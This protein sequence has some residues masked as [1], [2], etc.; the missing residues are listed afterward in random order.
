VISAL[1]S[2]SVL[3]ERVGFWWRRTRPT[4][5]TRRRSERQRQR[6]RDLGLERRW[7]RPEGE[8][9]VS[10]TLQVPSQRLVIELDPADQSTGRL[11]R[12]DPTSRDDAADPPARP[13][14]RT[15]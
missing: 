13:D 15:S 14:R 9:R 6:R 3:R 11:S 4:A 1:R 2:P 10:D 7:R 8:P 5:W 12:G